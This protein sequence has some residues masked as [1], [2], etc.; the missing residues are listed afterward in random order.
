MMKKVSVIIPCHNAVRWL[1][2]CF[3]SL[4]GQTIGIENLELIFVDDAS[5][6]DGKTWEMLQEFEQAYP[7]S[8][9]VI[10]LEENLRQGGARN[11]A[12][13]YATG[14][15]LAFVDAD[16][17]VGEDFL[18]K[19]YACAKETNADVVQ[20]EYFYYTEHA[21]AVAPER[22]VKNERVYIEGAESRKNFLVSEKITYGCWNKLY[23]HSVIQESGVR[24]AEHVVYE[25]PLFVYPLLFY[26][27]RFVIMEDRLYYYRQNMQ[28]TMRSDMKQMETLGMHARVQYMVWEFMKHTEFFDEFYEEIK[29]YFLHTFF[30]ETIYFA[31]IRGFGITLDGYRKLEAVVKREVPDY[32][33]SRYETL[34]PRQMELYQLAASG[35]TNEIL[36]DYIKRL[37]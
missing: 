30:Y 16:D 10:H 15:Y 23:K 26:G 35:M 36:A 32:Q 24:Y 9:L 37:Y 2:Q 22:S 18:K 5:T 6:D 7:D 33:T 14:E 1:P 21:G 8:I 28:G 13:S 17:F 20:F 27:N 19:V 29:L 11:T 12:L 3:L 25:E 31:A 4:V 34:I